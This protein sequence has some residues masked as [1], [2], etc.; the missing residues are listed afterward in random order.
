MGLSVFIV[1][2]QLSV[3]HLLVIYSGLDA[4]HPFHLHLRTC[5]DGTPVAHELYDNHP[6]LNWLYGQNSS[7]LILSL[8]QSF[9]MVYVWWNQL[10]VIQSITQLQSGLL[11][12][13]VFKQA[14]QIHGCWIQHNV[15]AKHATIFLFSKINRQ[16]VCASFCTQNL[17]LSDSSIEC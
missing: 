10:T 4:E 13:T 7:I 12:L 9:M 8:H 3:A 1:Q 15:S 2:N 14:V 16:R 17:V 6:F 11:N 5:Q